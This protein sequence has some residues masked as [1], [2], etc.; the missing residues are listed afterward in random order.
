[1]A[2]KLLKL[3]TRGP[4]TAAIRR[5]EK[6]R[7]QIFPH[8]SDDQIW[9]RA[10]FVGFTTIPRTMPIIMRIIDSLDIKKASRVYLD[11]WSRAFDDFFI[12]VKDE[13]D[14][15]YASGYSGQRAVRSWRERVMILAEHGFIQINANSYGRI[16]YIVVL[17]PHAIVQK[18]DDDG[19]LGDDDQL[20]FNSTMLAIGAA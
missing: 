10:T 17:E 5:R 12:D 6:L 3:K 15:A 2:T 14:F 9:N 1:M 13:N 11:L 8:V 16:R 19:L 18:L 7:E 4:A 20:A